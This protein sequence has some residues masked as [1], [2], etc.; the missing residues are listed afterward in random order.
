MVAVQAYTL[1]SPNQKTS[2]SRRQDQALA[3]SAH[4]RLA[5]AR[6]VDGEIFCP[7]IEGVQYNVQCSVLAK[8]RMLPSHRLILG[9]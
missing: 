8:R 3:A 2:K 7:T 5:S 4:F 1:I 9:R 6:E